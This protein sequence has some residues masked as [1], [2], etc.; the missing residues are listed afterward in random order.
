MDLYIL[1]NHLIIC[2]YDK[3]LKCDTSGSPQV[4]FVSSLLT[5]Q[6]FPRPGRYWSSRKRNQC[7]TMDDSRGITLRSL[8][9]I[10]LATLSG[11]ILSMLTLAHEVSNCE[12]SLL[13]RIC[14]TKVTYSHLLLLNMTYF[15]II[16][17]LIISHPQKC[18]TVSISPSNRCGSR[19]RRA[20]TR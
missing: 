18:V 14:K 17:Q 19:G 6:L 15:P 3:Q 16:C 7:P 12:Q 13:R 11:L 2:S 10:F 20:G 8:G 1:E 4:C 5:M 9:G